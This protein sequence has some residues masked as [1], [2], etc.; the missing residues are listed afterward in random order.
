MGKIVEFIKR[1]FSRDSKKHIMK[2]DLIEFN[3]PLDCNL[4]VSRLSYKKIRVVEGRDPLME[5]GKLCYY[6]FTHHKGEQIK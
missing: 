3:Y 6:D 2:V 4:P 5:M 1:L